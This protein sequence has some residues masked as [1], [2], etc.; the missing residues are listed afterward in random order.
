MIDPVKVIPVPLQDRQLRS[1]SRCGG[2]RPG[3]FGRFSSAPED[4]RHHTA[5][6]AAPLRS[7]N[8]QQG[9]VDPARFCC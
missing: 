5:D 3:G 9:P 6:L 8:L 2:R 1:D 4:K 7:S